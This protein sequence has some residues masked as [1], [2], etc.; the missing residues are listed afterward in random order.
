M[1]MIANPS[2]PGGQAKPG[3]NIRRLCEQNP[4]TMFVI[5]EAFAS[6]APAGTSLLESGPPP[7]NAVVVRSLTK[8]LAMP[9]L[10]MGYIVGDADLASQLNGVLPAWPLSAPAIAA[11]VAGLDDQSHVEAGALLGRQHVAELAA[12][13]A[14]AGAVPFRSDAN[15][16]VA[17]APTAA[18]E[19]RSSGIAVRDCTSFGL[20]GH[21][22]LAA[23]KRHEIGAVVTAIAGL[24]SSD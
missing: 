4:Q 21:V 5:D 18:A 7:K 13:L 3:T 16:L 20:P 9:G 8:D 11:A 12:A 6:F 1:L 10:R 15:Y 14:A 23:P 2:N 24:G 19:L 17:D 22:R